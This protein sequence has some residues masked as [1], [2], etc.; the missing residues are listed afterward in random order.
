[1]PMT[2]TVELA[3]EVRDAYDS[4]YY[5]AGQQRI[6]FDQFS[7]MRPQA[8]GG[9]VGQNVKFAIVEATQPNTAA[10]DEYTDVPSQRMRASEK[11]VLLSEYGGA[12]SVNKYLVATSY[13]DVLEQ[14]ALTNGY[15]LA[16]SVDKIV[17]AVAGQGNRVFRP[18]SGIT[19][20]TT[21]GL[22]TAGHRVSA[23]LI[24][25]IANLCQSMGMP[26]Y[27]DN[28]ICAV[29]HP[30]PWHDLL[31][32]DDIR[33][34]SSRQYPEILFNG[35]LAYWS[36]IRFIKT[37]AAKAFWGAGAARSAAGFSSTLAAASDIG[38]TNLKVTAT[39]NLQ[40]DE[41]MA[42]QDGAETG[43]TWYDTNEIFRVTTVGT[44]G[45]GG[46]GIDGYVLDFAQGDD[47]GTRY[48]H[49]SGTAI[50]DAAS[51][52]PISLIGPHSITKVASDLTGNFGTTVV[53]GPI[54]TLGRFLSFGWYLIAGWAR[55]RAQWA[56]RLEV[57]SSI[58]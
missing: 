47:G 1:M 8:P 57:G 32:D 58:S 54:D 26:L 15:N 23:T 10:L 33:T 19:R 13:N 11:G 7:H 25:Q 4:D 5:L 18:T 17:R 34:M 28:S 38:A 42:I 37:P 39:T 24:E 51:V 9:Q 56:P 12:V 27:D 43:N 3:S 44:S 46:T 30:F 52:Y 31:Q 36:G 35:E 49:A 40:V 2:G 16:E 55:T 21:N 48:A 14:A 6:Y 22:D 29:I 45:A 50:V 41:W 53:T 20:A